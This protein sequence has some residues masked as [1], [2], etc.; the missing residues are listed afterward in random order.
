MMCHECLTPSI[1]SIIGFSMRSSNASC[2][3]YSEGPSYSDQLYE[4][5]HENE[6]ENEVNMDH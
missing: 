2:S 5:N 6:E 3:S 1:I 4:L